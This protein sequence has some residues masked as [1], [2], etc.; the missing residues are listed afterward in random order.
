M[1]S[2]IQLR[3]SRMI[4]RLEKIASRDCYCNEHDDDACKTCVAART[5]NRVCSDVFDTLNEL[6]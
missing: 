4:T 3:I 6:E 1:K 2:V 5:L